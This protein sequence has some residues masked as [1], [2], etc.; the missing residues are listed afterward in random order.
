MSKYV[1]DLL[2][3]NTKYD[4][5]NDSTP[6]SKISGSII[7]K[8]TLFFAYIIGGFLLFS[9]LITL[10]I[11]FW[12][13]FLLLLLGGIIFPKGHE[14][15]ENKL[16]FKL[17]PIPKTL[18]IILLI[19]G[20]AGTDKYYQGK[21]QKIKK[22]K[23]EQELKREEEI[24]LAK[25]NEQLRKDSLLFYQDFVISYLDNDKETQLNKE[26]FERMFF[27]VKT[28]A[29]S[30]E[31]YSIEID[32]MIKSMKFNSAISTINT[33]IENDYNL[34]DSYLKRAECYI[35][36]DSIQLAVNDLK[37]AIKLGNNEAEPLYEKINPVKKEFI[38]YSTLCCDGTTTSNRGRGACSGHKGVCN[39]NH[40]IYREYRKY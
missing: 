15:I 22:L 26:D 9:A 37:Q 28:K 40:K 7:K 21:N 33:L 29:D 18:F 35:K 34:G 17:K 3:E 1:P 14:L 27:F 10:F 32:Y 13:G 38:G 5:S 6:K 19:V 24:Q 36:I 11:Q 25:Q 39:W 20:I 23:E 2:P 30:L 12:A 31:T 16:R 4:F 8:T